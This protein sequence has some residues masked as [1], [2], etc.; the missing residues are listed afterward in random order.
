MRIKEEWN[1]VYYPFLQLLPSRQSQF[2]DIPIGTLLNPR[3]TSTQW[4][5][6]HVEASKIPHFPMISNHI[7]PANYH[8][9]SPIHINRITPSSSRGVATDNGTIPS[10]P[11]E[12]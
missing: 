4:H 11:C 12:R 1:W 2:H 10:G 7:P 8:P 3:Q 5:N 9:P 6:I